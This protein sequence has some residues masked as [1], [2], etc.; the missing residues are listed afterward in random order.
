M[1][2]PKFA[3]IF[4]GL[5]QG[6]ERGVSNYQDQMEQQ[7]RAMLEQEQMDLERSRLENAIMMA[8]AENERQKVEAAQEAERFGW[9]RQ[10][11]LE[12]R[13]PIP[14]TPDQLSQGPVNFTNPSPREL[15]NQ[16]SL[17]GY[18]TAQ[19]EAAMKHKLMGLEYPSGLSDIPGNIPL[20]AFEALSPLYSLRAAQARATE[21]TDDSVKMSFVNQVQSYY[22]QS[23]DTQA[24]M[25]GSP[26]VAGVPS[27]TPDQ[28]PQIE[29]RALENTINF[30][31]SQMAY[32]PDPISMANMSGILDTYLQRYNALTA[33]LSTPAVD[34]GGG[35][36]W[37]GLSGFMFGGGEQAPPPGGTMPGATETG[38]SP[39]DQQ[40][41]DDLMLQ[42]HGISG[43]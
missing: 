18:Q 13:Q 29:L 10:S 7:R 28:I 43:R 32:H 5:G 19:S 36:F 4:A 37:K 17:L 11:Q 25:S 27:P 33:K 20:P 23:W 26:V 30:I 35:G 40:E 22:K 31:Q 6:L 1:A 21:S 9:E 42:Y 15:T 39:E 2:G 12:T 3:N 8:Q 14:L 24:M 38:L 41:Y 16:T 34:T